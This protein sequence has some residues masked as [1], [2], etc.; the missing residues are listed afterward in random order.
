MPLASWL[1]GEQ[2]ELDVGIF[3]SVEVVADFDEGGP[4]LRLVA[5]SDT[6]LR[7]GVEIW[8]PVRARRTLPGFRGSSEDL[9]LERIGG[10]E[11]SEGT[12][13][14]E[15]SEPGEMCFNVQDDD[16][17]GAIDCADLH[18]ARDTN[19]IDDQDDLAERVITC[20]EDYAPL[21][22][23][24]L[25]R[26]DSQRTLYAT[27]EGTVEHPA[28]EF[29]G[30]AEIVLLEAPGAASLSLRFGSAGLVCAAATP[31]ETSVHCQDTRRVQAGDVYETSVD[32]LPIYLEPD[33]A[34]WLGIE[35]RGDCETENRDL[36]SAP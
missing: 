36:S 18:C 4:A 32:A 2:L 28:D 1:P 19:C 25:D 34:R 14:L 17:D 5:T 11:V 6:A 22:V 9:S 10:D 23:P 35:A 12:L 26:L 30:G 7:R 15:C 8:D 31:G 13:T 29:R 24:E 3:T 16:G 27:T 33:D 21:D 20:S